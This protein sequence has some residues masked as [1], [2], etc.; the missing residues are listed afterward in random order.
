MKPSTGMWETLSELKQDINRIHEM[1]LDS[2]RRLNR[3]TSDDIAMQERQIRARLDSFRLEITYA[4]QRES[5]K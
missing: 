5:G 2:N 3:V 1:M 4:I